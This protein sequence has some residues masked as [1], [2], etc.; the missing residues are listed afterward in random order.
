LNHFDVWRD[1]KYC[2][3]SIVLRCLFIVCKSWFSAIVHYYL[4][5]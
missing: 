5:D 2:K 1:I 4:Y 3:S